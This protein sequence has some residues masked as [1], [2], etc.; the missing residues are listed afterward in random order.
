MLEGFDVGHEVADWS[1]IDWLWINGRLVLRLR[2]IDYW[3]HESR[4]IDPHGTSAA[5][6]EGYRTDNGADSHDELFADLHNLDLQ[7]VLRVEGGSLGA[8]SL[9]A[10]V[11]L[12]SV[13]VC[14][15]GVSSRPEH[16]GVHKHVGNTAVRYIRRSWRLSAILDA[17]LHEFHGLAV[18][19]ARDEFVALC[20]P[21]QV[22]DI[23]FDLRRGSG[24]SSVRAR[25]SGLLWLGLALRAVVHQLGDR[26]GLRHAVSADVP[27][28]VSQLRIMP[29]VLRLPH[30][31]RR[32][33][34]AGLGRRLLGYPVEARL[35]WARLVR[36]ADDGSLGPPGRQLCALLCR[37]VVHRLPRV[38][39]SA[40]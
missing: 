29:A 14:R 24:A 9:A 26:A 40:L 30:P 10:M 37:C 7:V 39:T 2:P 18:G 34:K 38:G 32:D 5:F 33:P 17:L 31:L 19:D 8:A 13:G 1:G 22:P 11:L 28:G 6:V 20:E 16:Q 27:L 3:H 4:T 23:G 35:P 12:V 15:D 25:G 21:F 36:S